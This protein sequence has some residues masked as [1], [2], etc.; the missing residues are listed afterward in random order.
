LASAVALLVAVI[1]AAFKLLKGAFLACPPLRFVLN[2]GALDKTG[3]VF[4]IALFV[5]WVLRHDVAYGRRAT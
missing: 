3:L 2:L 4:R 5:A 1:A